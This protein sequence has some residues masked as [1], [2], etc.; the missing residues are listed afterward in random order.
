MGAC[1]GGG[2]AMRRARLLLVDAVGDRVASAA[3]RA[4][5]ATAL[6]HRDTNISRDLRNQGNSISELL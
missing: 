2:M 1:A 4:Q 5:P 3:S 6:L